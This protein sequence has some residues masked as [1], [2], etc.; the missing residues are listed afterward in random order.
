[1]KW[2]NYSISHQTFTLE[3][4]H[5]LLTLACINHYDDG[6]KVVIS[7]APSILFH[8]LVGILFKEEF[9]LLLLFILVLSNLISF[10]NCF[11]FFLICSYHFFVLPPLLVQ[12]YQKFLYFIRIFRDQLLDL[13]TALGLVP[14]EA[15]HLWLANNGAGQFKG[16]PIVRICIIYS[17]DELSSPP[18]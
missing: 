10:H 5:S 4:Q 7:L 13:L 3:L 8:L 1:M 14:A 18:G 15:D 9:F 16:K 11:F 12:S 6:C 2:W 17:K